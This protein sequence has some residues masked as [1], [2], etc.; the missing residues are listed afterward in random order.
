MAVVFAV[1]IRLK[2]V[3]ELFQRD[4]SPKQFQEEFG[5]GSLPRIAQHFERLR[6]TG[7][8]R[9]I[10]SEGPGGKRRGGVETI[11]RATELAFCDRP[12]WAALPHSIKVAFSWNTFV[13]IAEQFRAALE[14]ETVQAR[15]DLPLSGTRLLLDMEGWRRVADAVSQEFADQFEE[16]EDARRRAERTGGELFRIGSTLLAFELPISEGF[17][18]G[19]EL[20]VGETLMIPFPVRVSK[21]FEDEVCLQIMDEANRGSISVPEFHKKYGKRFGLGRPMIRRRF[22][23]LVQYGWLKVVAY[24][25]GG[26]RRGGTEKFYGATG[27]AVYDEDERGPWAKVSDDFSETKDWQVF[28]EISRWAKA[29]MAAGTIVR[30]DETCL[31]WPILNLDEQGWEKIV[32]SMEKLHAFILTEQE[33]AEARLREG[34]GE[35]I[36]MVVA[37]GA[38]E[39]PAPVKEP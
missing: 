19:P 22:D 26:K 17:Q 29:S 9:H 24:E 7:W 36:A 25:S 37:L 12:T 34:D 39:M 15:P 4:M 1:P 10:R 33:L 21:L 2:I 20:V 13:E 23:K 30:H 18:F 8:L 27:P 14:A 38:F 5:G 3:T 28:E 11:Y 32:A 31:A 6:E 16:Q 35:P